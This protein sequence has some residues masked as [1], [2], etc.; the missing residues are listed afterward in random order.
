MKPEDLVNDRERELMQPYY[1]SRGPLR[2][3]LVD[4]VAV[5]DKDQAKLGQDS[6]VYMFFDPLLTDEMC[7]VIKG[8]KLRKL[9]YPKQIAK[10]C[11]KSIEEVV[12]LGLEMS[13]IG[14]LEVHTDDKGQDMFY[15]PQLCVGA[16]EWTMVGPTYKDHPEQSLLF[17][18]ETFESFTGKG[19]FLPMSNHGVH[20]TVP[21]ETAITPDTKRMEWEDLVKLIERNADN[22]YAVGKCICRQGRLVNGT[23]SGEPS[24]EWC[25]TMGD[26]A[27]YC[28]RTG[29]ARQ[30]TKEEFYGILK[31]AEERGFVHNVA[32]ANGK[33][34]IE[35]ICNCD[36][37]TCYTIRADLYSSNSSMTR[38]NFVAQ[39]DPEKCVACG[40]CVETCPENAV[41]MG[42]RLDPK[43][44]I[45]YHYR[46]T[47]HEYLKWG[48]E[49]WHPDYLLERENVWHETGTAPCK[50]A[51]PAHVPV[52][53]YLRLAAQGKYNE[54]LALIKHRNPLP[55]VCGSICN[56]RC[57]AACTR[58]RIDEPVAIDEVKKFLAHRDLAAETRY[59]PKKKPTRGTEGKKVAVIGS[60]PAGLTCAYYLQIEGEQVTIFEKH[61][62]VGG[63][64]RYG[65]P[66]F[67]LE[68]DVMDAE[69][70]IIR[71]LGAEFR[72]GVEVG[73]DVT[74]QQL[75]EQ[76]YEAF[77]IAI[78]CQSGR[79]VNVPG[80]D[81]DGVL[82]AVD[83]LQKYAATKE[84]DVPGDVVIIGGGN[85]AVDTARTAVRLGG[86][87]LVDTA[88]SAARFGS[89]K[90]YMYC[91]ESREEM[92]AAPDEMEEAEADGIVVDC[93]W[94]PKEIL[95]E[96]GHVAGIVMKKCLS[97]KD[98]EG[99]FRPQYDEDNTIT[100]PCRYVVLAVGQSVVWGD[101]LK[102]E[103][104][105]LRGGN[106]PVADQQ[107]FQTSVPDIFV[108]GDVFTGPQWSIDAIACGKEGAESIHRYVWKGNLRTGRD[109]N[110]YQEIQKDN[111]LF[112]NY[113]TA[114]RQRCGRT[115]DKKHSFS[116]DR[117]VFTEEQVKVETARCLK[118]GASHVDENMCLGCGVCTTRCKFD[119][120]HLRRV[121]ECTPTTRE[122]LVPA[123]LGE[124]GRRIVWNKFHE[125]SVRTVEVGI[126]Q[127]NPN[128]SYATGA[129]Y[130]KPPKK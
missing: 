45:Q 43:T 39:V 61:E 58:G 15:V 53:G 8:M 47:P 57:E 97:V 120:I 82:S 24:H 63:M 9:M 41:R 96:D 119:A 70:E 91:L 26:F 44:P 79:G 64:L 50:T 11:G 36:Y 67:R 122:N 94:G 48:E 113:D 90:T 127:M 126:S 37:K 73:R 32:N 27:R 30:I 76:G 40:M 81:A 14:A 68:K 16:L 109:R 86:N 54:A 115:D 102:G 7:E 25:T 42:Q 93:G 114:H 35:Y 1:D 99:R 60:G 17:E 65:V 130:H 2:Q 128:I 75:R 12:R 92:P 51:C 56:R 52:E 116:D 6:T 31:D 13:N 123:V 78:G 104:V 3:C 18:H 121:F 19:K 98:A 111:V 117:E 72:T 21:I 101:L 74:I 105:E 22:F 106:Y 10:R 23:S 28:V 110:L 88:R 108:G 33:N 103:D 38:S 66:S 62:K 118:C 5:Y 59:I 100:I 77:Y 34:K 4:A 129:K 107:T 46:E 95:T 49:R 124:V 89:G 83:F 84:L 20:R 125:P 71:E 69:I 55:A 87:V 80:E 29:K 85:V 112:G